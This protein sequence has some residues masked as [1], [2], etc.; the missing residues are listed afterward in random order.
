MKH[1]LLLGLAL[2]Y[3]TVYAQPAFTGPDLSGV[4]E[5]EGKDAHEG[6]YSAIVTL[7]LNR[8]QSSGVNGAYGFQF[9]VLGFGAYPGHAVAHGKNMAIHFANTDP[10]SK[11]LGTGIASFSKNK[12]GKWTFTKY[13]YEPEYKGGNIG[14]ESCVQQ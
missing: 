1:A 14:S 11:E 7:A 4:Y 5:C 13:Y 10:A 9:D 2:S 8:T 12:A 3:G 6:E